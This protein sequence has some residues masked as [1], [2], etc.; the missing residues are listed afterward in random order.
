VKHNQQTQIYDETL[1][2]LFAHEIAK[3]LPLLLP[4]AEFLSE[5][6]IEINRTIVKADLLFW[7]TWSYKATEMIQ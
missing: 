7:S 4:G 1:K 6:N 2:S 5:S 3:I